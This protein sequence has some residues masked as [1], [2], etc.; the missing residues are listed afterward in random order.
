VRLEEDG[1]V[2]KNQSTLEKKQK[3]KNNN[4]TWCVVHDDSRPT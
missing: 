1:G 3:Q 2:A 4:E